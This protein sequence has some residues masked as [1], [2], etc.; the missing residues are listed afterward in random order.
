MPERLPV[1]TLK[2]PKPV[3]P[4]GILLTVVM[5]ACVAVAATRFGR[6]AR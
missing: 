1:L 4:L 6:R 2:P 3:I 5:T